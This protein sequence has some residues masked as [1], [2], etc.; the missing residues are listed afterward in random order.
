[1]RGN[2]GGRGRALVAP[3]AAALLL[4][5]ALA[6]LAPPASAHHTGTV[7]PLG[8]SV[9]ETVV[10]PPE[11]FTAYEGNL[12]TADRVA[13]DIEVTNGSAIDLYIVPEE[14]FVRYANHSY[15]SFTYY[16][17][18]ENATRING[19]FG[20]AS[21]TVVFIVDNVGFT[22]AVPQGNVTVHVSLVRTTEPPASE[23]PSLF[24]GSLLATLALTLVL[25][26]AGFLIRRRKRPQAPPVPPPTAPAQAPGEPPPPPPPAEAAPALREI[27]PPPPPPPP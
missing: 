14:S 24:C 10:L 25:G 5:A 8:A 12:T 1:M 19:T 2:R 6:A 16:D 27:P 9:N 3:V 20:G 15:T 7:R 22:G 13:Y 26:L 17:M 23:L 4:A 11:N 18:K 21:G